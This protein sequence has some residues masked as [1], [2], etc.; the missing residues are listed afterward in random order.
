MIKLLLILM[1]LFPP[2]DDTKPE[3]EVETSSRPVLELGE[4]VS[5]T[6]S[7]HLGTD[8]SQ[9]SVVML[10]LDLDGFS[11]KS[12]TKQTTLGGSVFDVPRK[13]SFHVVLEA[14]ETGNGVLNE[15]QVELIP[16]GE[17]VQPILLTHPGFTAQIT[18]PFRF[19]LYLP[20]SLDPYYWPLQ[21]YSFISASSIN[22]KTRGKRSYLPPRKEE[23][24]P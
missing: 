1:V 20:G 13:I 12:L 14:D 19:E 22:L 10:P 21:G 7:M 11:V 4:E 23:Q 17:N 5:I 15:I 18:E 16:P 3:L 6:V 9:Y 2:Q 24:N 8:K